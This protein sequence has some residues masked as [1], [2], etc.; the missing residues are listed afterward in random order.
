M[1]LP[2]LA[3]RRS[4]EDAIEIY[5]YLHGIYSVDCCDLGL[6]YDNMISFRF[7]VKKSVFQLGN[8]KKITA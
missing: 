7:I 2:S 3:Y 4:R 5:E 1:D 6:L 8:L